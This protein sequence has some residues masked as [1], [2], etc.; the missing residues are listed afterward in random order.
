MSKIQLLDCTLRDGGYVNDWEF[1]Y[2]NLISIFERCANAGVD[3]IEV[4]F[5]DERRPYDKNRSIMPDTESAGKIWE[6]VQEKPAMVVGMIDYGTC[7]ISNLQPCEESFLDGIRVI[8]KEHRMKEAMDFCAQVK[9]LGYKVFAQLVSITTYTEKGLL[10]LVKLVNEVKPYAVSMVDT[11]GLLYPETLL[12]YYKVL[13]K[14]VNLDIQI[15]F[16]AHNNLQMA[17]ANA[18]TFLSYKGHHDIIVD[19]TLYGMGKSA[20]NA[21]LEL[22]AMYINTISNRKYKVDAMLESIEESILD[23]FRRKP[24]GY[25]LQF[26]LSASNKCHPNYVTYFREKQN[27]SVSKVDKLLKTIQPEDKKLLYDKLVAEQQYQNYTEHIGKDEEQKEQLRSILEWRALLLIGPG[28]NIGLQ[29]HKVEN[30]IKRNKPC[31]IAINYIPEGIKVDFVFVTNGRRYHELRIRGEKIIATSNIECRTGAFAYVVDRLPLIE[32]G[33]KIVDNSFLMLLRLLQS[34]GIRE[35]NCAGFDGYS[36]KEDNYVDPSM[37]YGFVKREAVL[38]NCHI[39]ECIKI[40][41]DKMIIKFI[42][43]SAYDEEE[44]IDQAAY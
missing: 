13:D 19:G 23:F 33:E 32:S 21:P 5:L 39:R 1:G 24:W 26:F 27:L 15:G 17:Y 34:L 35:V 16:H 8:F 12:T 29:K 11:Y 38:L 4:G 41:R 43:Y 10:D 18:L 28:K 30:F 3:I 44:N 6:V 20:G 9:A 36:E 37:E 31:V 14:Y 42:T 2:S 40:L 25:Q 22:L 7:S